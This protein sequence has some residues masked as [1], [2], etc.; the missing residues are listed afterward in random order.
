MDVH[1]RGQPRRSFLTRIRSRMR[2]LHAQELPG[3][4]ADLSPEGVRCR[5]VQNKIPIRSNKGR[6][7]YD[8]R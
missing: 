1:I 2:R 6:H 5:S 4:F 8:I 7:T 3:A